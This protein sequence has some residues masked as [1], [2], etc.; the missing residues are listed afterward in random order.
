MCSLR[1][2]SKKYSGGNN[3]DFSSVPVGEEGRKEH[4]EEGRK[5]DGWEGQVESERGRENETLC[6]LIGVFC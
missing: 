6:L 5:E 4:G 1:S 3:L 2:Q